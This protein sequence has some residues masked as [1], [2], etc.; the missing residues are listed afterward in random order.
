[1]WVLVGRCGQPMP[2]CDDIGFARLKRNIDRILT[3][4]RCHE[5]ESV[6]QGRRLYQRLAIRS[7]VWSV[8]LYNCNAF[9]VDIAKIHWS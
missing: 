8:E 7:H 1:M 5:Q 6:R 2:V 3:D 9:V 4:N